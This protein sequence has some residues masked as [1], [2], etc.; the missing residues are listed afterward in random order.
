MIPIKPFIV[1]LQPAM[2]LQSGL[3]FYHSALRLPL[4]YAGDLYHFL[5]CMILD[6]HGAYGIQLVLFMVSNSQIVSFIWY[7]IVFS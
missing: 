7:V 3:I 2:Y 4:F 6:R 1:Y 5:T